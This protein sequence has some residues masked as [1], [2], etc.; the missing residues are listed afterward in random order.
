MAAAAARRWRVAGVVQGVGFRWFVAS[1]GRHL[2]LRGF[3][4]NLPDGTV[5]VVAAGAPEAL[6]RLERE[7]RVG[8][9]GASVASVVRLEATVEEAGD[10][11]FQ[12][13]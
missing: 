5:E 1:T 6:D 4:R 13:K 11:R 12:V 8:P 9:A 7:L 2:D 10:K 3:A